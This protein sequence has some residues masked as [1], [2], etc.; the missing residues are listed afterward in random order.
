MSADASF[1][2]VAELGAEIHAR[3]ISCADAAQQAFDRIHRFDPTLNSFIH[4]RLRRRVRTS[5]T[6]R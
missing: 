2:S 6:A 5:E 4:A 1:Q 3:R